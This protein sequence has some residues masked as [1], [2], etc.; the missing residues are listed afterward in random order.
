MLELM[1]DYFDKEVFTLGHQ[2]R[3][4]SKRNVKK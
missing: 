2:E 4:I 1:V 3:V